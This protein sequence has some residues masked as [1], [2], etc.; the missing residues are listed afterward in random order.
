MVTAAV[1]PLVDAGKAAGLLR[2]DVTVGD[3]ILVK[4]AVAMARPENARRLAA[5]L[6]DGLRHGAPA[7][8]SPPGATKKAARRSG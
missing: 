8:S 6:V 7:R 5:I 3:G 4:G 1:A 2:A